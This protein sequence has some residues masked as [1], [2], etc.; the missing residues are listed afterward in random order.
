MQNPTLGKEEPL[1]QYRLGLMG[2]GAALQKRIWV[3]RQRASWAWARSVPW[4][5]KKPKAEQPGGWQMVY[6]ASLGSDGTGVPNPVLDPQ[7][8]KNM[9]TLEQ[10][11]QTPPRGLRA[12]ALWGEAEGTGLVWPQKRWL[13][14]RQPT[15]WHLLQ[16]SYQQDGARLFN[17]GHG[18]RTRDNRP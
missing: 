16:G 7:C 10:L 12:R 15:A 3:S 14:R 1:Q 6:P 13:W 5:Q 9:D 8:K 17:R 18:G 11:Q 4:Q 2:R